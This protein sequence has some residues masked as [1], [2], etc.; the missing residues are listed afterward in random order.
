MLWQS[1]DYQEMYIMNIHSGTSRGRY[2]YTGSCDLSHDVDYEGTAS[3]RAYLITKI[4]LNDV[5]S[6]LVDFHVFMVLE[7]LDFVKSLTLLNHY[8]NLLHLRDALPR[9]QKSHAGHMMT[10][11]RN[12][13]RQYMYGNCK[14]ILTFVL[15]HKTNEYKLFPA[16]KNLRKK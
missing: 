11:A 3:I 2:T 13:A 15:S 16:N 8:A 14:T 6:S 1:H 10:I 7:S 4:L 9:L 12:Y 5:Q